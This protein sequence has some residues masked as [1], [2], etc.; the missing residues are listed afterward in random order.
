LADSYCVATAAF[1]APSQ[2]ASNNFSQIPT[3]VGDRITVDAVLI[4]QQSRECFPLMM[5]PMLVA[6]HPA[7]F[8][9]YIPAGRYNQTTADSVWRTNLRCQSATLAVTIHLRRWLFTD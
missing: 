9:A 2:A 6:G 4:R 1:V 3:H 7:K 5:R 8:N